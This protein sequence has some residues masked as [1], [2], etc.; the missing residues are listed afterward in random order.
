MAGSFALLLRQY[1]TRDPISA[2]GVRSDAEPGTYFSCRTLCSLTLGNWQKS[3]P[4][5]GLPVATGGA[6]D[7]ALKTPYWLPSMNQ[8]SIRKNRHVP[9]IR[10]RS[11]HGILHSVIS[12]CVWLKHTNPYLTFLRSAAFQN[13]IT[14]LSPRLLPTVRDD[15]TTWYSDGSKLTR[16]LKH[17]HGHV[18]GRYEK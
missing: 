9:K 7:G 8:T 4:N 6:D 1:Q 12:F 5:A 18:H 2:T 3:H 10:N 16:K 13:R 15:S 11:R 17:D 14:Y